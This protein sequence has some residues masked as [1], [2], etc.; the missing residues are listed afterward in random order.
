M[1]CAETC[2]PAGFPLPKGKE[3]MC[4]ISLRQ[5]CSRPCQTPEL[6][7]PS[8]TTAESPGAS[9]IPSVLRSHLCHHEGAWASRT[10][11]PAAQS[12][13]LYDPCPTPMGQAPAGPSSRHP[14]NWLAHVLHSSAP[15]L[16]LWADMSFHA[17]AQA[18]PSLR[19]PW[20]LQSRLCPGFSP[21]LL[22]DGGQSR[23][24]CLRHQLLQI[25]SPYGVHCS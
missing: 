2:S 24:G 3:L 20:L 18:L 11:V 7:Q 12:P 25:C 14:C 10:P 23:R 5:P 13:S 9:E 22:K 15:Q 17:Y 21:S 6:L 4:P 16:M 1:L 19:G 8:V